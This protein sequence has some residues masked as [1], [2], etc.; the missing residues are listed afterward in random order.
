MRHHQ[1]FTLVE[2]IITLVVVGVLAAIVFPRASDLSEEAAIAKAQGVAG[3]L[4][5]VVNTVKAIFLSQGH[6]IRV[7]DLQGFGN[8]NVDTNNSGYPIGIDKGNGNE[9]VGRNQKGCD[10]LWDGLLVDAPTTAFNN[11]S[12]DYRSFR[13]TSNKICSYVYRRNG[14][15]G[16]QNTGQIIIRY[17]SRDGTVRVCGASSLLDPC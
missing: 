8:N 14:D 4:R 2:L 1:G 9:N 6:T 11:N 12:Q 5:S 16:N 13:H 3:S 15:S 17:D 10:E 7:Q